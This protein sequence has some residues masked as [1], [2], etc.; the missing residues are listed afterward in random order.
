[1]ERSQNMLFK[2]GYVRVALLLGIFCTSFCLGQTK[3]VGKP[4]VCKQLAKDAA[5]YANES[6]T[7]SKMG[8]FISNPKLGQRNIDTAIYFMNVSVVFLDSAISLASDSELMGIDLCNTA[9]KFARRA[10][11]MQKAYKNF[12]DAGQRKLLAEDAT[13]FAGNV[14]TDAYHASF[15]FIDGT[16]PQ[17]EIKP[18]KD[19][20]PKQITKL[21]IDQAL[22]ALLDGQLIEKEEKDKKEIAKLE[23]QLKATKDPAKIAKLKAEIKKLEKDE[24]ELEKK[25]KDAKQKLTQINAELAEREKNK[26][27]QTQADAN[28][29]SKSLSK[30][31]DWNKDVLFDSELPMGLVYQVQIGVYKNAVTAETFKGITPIFAKTTAAGVTY[32]AGIFEKESDAKQAKDY[33][34]SMGLHDAFVIVYL[35][36]KRISLA[37]AAK[38]EKK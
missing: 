4:G 23:T 27:K 26:T 9:K 3:I 22:F 32:S 15:Y 24:A 5:H 34:I 8:Y 33:V 35:D 25:D 31:N 18:V 21:D 29:F 14:V 38:L 30:P 17:K 1:M 11:K 28:A 20:T 10:L 13:V 37:E 6:Y 19:T 36:K 16:P 12:T 2:P 7:Y